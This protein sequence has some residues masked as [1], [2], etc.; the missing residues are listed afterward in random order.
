MLKEISLPDQVTIGPYTYKLISRS[1]DWYD[2]VEAYGSTWNDTRIINVALIGD[3]ACIL[4]TL[5]HECLH[6]MWAMMHMESSVKEEEAVSK[7]S[8]S[9]VLLLKQNPFIVKLINDIVG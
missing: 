3:P 7:M 8:T 4:D 9:F 6:A 5:I 2:E 1:K